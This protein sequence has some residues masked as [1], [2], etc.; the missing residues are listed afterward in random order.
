MAEKMAADWVV[1]RVGSKVLWVWTRVD[2]TVER[3]VGM[4]A[5]TVALM[6]DMTVAWRVVG[7]DATTAAMMA[8]T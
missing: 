5:M 4:V 2:M 6:V 1:W 8:V 7:M 3:K